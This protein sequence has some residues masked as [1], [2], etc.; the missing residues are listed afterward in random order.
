MDKQPS[1]IG[2]TL[3]GRYKI[4]EMPGQGNCVDQQQQNKLNEQPDLQRPGCF[5]L[6]CSSIPHGPGTSIVSQ[7]LI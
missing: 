4:E 5:C 6:F 3:S 2:R 1:W 7:K